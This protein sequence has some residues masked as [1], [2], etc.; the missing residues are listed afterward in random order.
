MMLWISFDQTG[1]RNKGNTRLPYKLCHFKSCCITKLR[2]RQFTQI[3]T[4]LNFILQG[5]L[6]PLRPRRGL[7]R[8]WW[9]QWTGG[10]FLSC[11]PTPSENIW[12]TWKWPLTRLETWWNRQETQ[13]CWT[14]ASHKVIPLFFILSY[15]HV[16]VL[17]KRKEWPS[18]S[19]N[20]FKSQ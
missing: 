17:K 12:V 20:G 6:P 5:H 13:S 3:L 4:L 10:R 15:L 9:D 7:I 11:R 18:R 19:E 8:S 14:A 16:T 1:P 2:N